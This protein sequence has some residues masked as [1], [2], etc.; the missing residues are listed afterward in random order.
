MSFQPVVP[1]GGLA[2][3][4]FLQRTLDTQRAA[5]D[6]SPA[7]AREEA[8]FRD[9]IGQIDSAEELVADRRLLKVALEAYG[10]G[11]DLQSKAFIRKVLEG[12]TLKEGALANRLADKRYREFSAAFGFGDFT[13]P[14]TKLSD[15]ADKMLGL[16]RG[17]SFETAVG[18]QDNDL[19]LALNLK[20]DLS[21]IAGGRLSADGKWFAVMGNA[22]LRQVFE[23]AFGLPSS[24]AG[25]DLDRQLKTFRARA[26]Q[27]FGNGEVAQFTDPE[28]IE[29]LTRR[30]LVRGD[31]TG[32][33]SAPG[34]AALQLLSAAPSLF[35]RA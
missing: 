1:F 24:F 28:K 27:A 2:G 15:F 3:W 21:E 16:W 18:A 31:A 17:R 29:A 11:G 35:R 33:L 14:R 4:S 32:G 8:Y 26:E 23:R 25:V 9:K 7:Q 20:R 19:R 22:P 30:F 10:L 34:A 12:G 13:V 5:F 6:R